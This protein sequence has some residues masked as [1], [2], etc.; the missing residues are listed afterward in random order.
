MIIYLQRFK[1]PQ[2]PR[3]H[4]LS[5]CSDKKIETQ[6]GDVPNVTKLG[7]ELTFNV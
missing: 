3:I 6:R 1:R 5:Y 7:A 4:F 2:A